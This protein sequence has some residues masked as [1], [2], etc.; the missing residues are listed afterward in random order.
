MSRLTFSKILLVV[1]FSIATFVNA[2]DRPTILAESQTQNTV[3]KQNAV[4]GDDS[5]S[6]NS[7]KKSEQNTEIQFSKSKKIKKNK[8]KKQR[9]HR[10]FSLGLSFRKLKKIREKN[11]GLVDRILRI[12]IAGTLIALYFTNTLTGALGI[13]GLVV[14]GIFLV[15]SIIGTCPMYCLLGFKTCPV[16]KTKNKDEKE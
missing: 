13:I 4:S 2:K 15:V 1:L 11:M 16:K 3:A 14:A 9:K 10:F 7:F 5:F 6:K 12:A 8:V